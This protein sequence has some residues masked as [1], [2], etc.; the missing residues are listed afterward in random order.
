MPHLISLTLILGQ[1]HSTNRLTKSREKISA[2]VKVELVDIKTINSDQ[3]LIDKHMNYVNILLKRQFPEVCGLQDTVPGQRLQFDV[4][5]TGEWIQIIHDGSLPWLTCTT[6]GC[7]E[8]EINNYDSLYNFLSDET[9]KQVA[10]ILHFRGNTIKCNFKNFQKQVGSVDCGLFAIAAATHL[11]HEADPS[12]FVYNQQAMSKHLI[13][14]LENEKMSV[15]PTVYDNGNFIEKKLPT[16][17]CINI[18][19]ECSLPVKDGEKV[20]DVAKCT[21]CGKVRHLS[22]LR[23]LSAQRSYL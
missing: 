2:E 3:M 1:S 23:R 17:C 19:S 21:N 15:F 9:Q 16:V 18:C 8:G 5:P 22:C 13:E 11:R 14:C 10:S 7:K 20:Q 4:M 6:I 12:Q